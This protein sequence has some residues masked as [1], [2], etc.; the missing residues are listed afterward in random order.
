V[1]FFGPG[2]D[3]IIMATRPVVILV[4]LVVHFLGSI[5]SK[6]PKAPSFQIGSG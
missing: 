2:T 5:S 6:M 4:L 3:L 1:I